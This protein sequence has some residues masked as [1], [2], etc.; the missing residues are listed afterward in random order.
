MLF[1]IGYITGAA[2]SVGIPCF[3]FYVKNHKINILCF[4]FLKSHDTQSIVYFKKCLYLSD[5]SEPQDN[6]KWCNLLI[7]GSRISHRRPLRVV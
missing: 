6:T 5:N 7:K 4:T 2:R 1:S 3:H